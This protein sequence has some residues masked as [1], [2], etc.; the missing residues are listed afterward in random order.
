M[1][2]A[3]STLVRGAAI[4][5]AA[6]A[7]AIATPAAAVHDEFELDGDIADSSSNPSPDWA[8]FFDATGAQLPLPPHFMASDFVRDF[9][10]N[11][12][13]PDFTTFTTGSKD[14]L[15]IG[16]GWQCARSSN[17]NSK[18]DLLNTYATFFVDPVTGDRQVYFGLERASNAGD[19]NVAI[20]FLQD[21][22]VG[23]VAP[24]RGSGAAYFAGNHIDGDLLVVSSFTNGGA[25]STVDVFKWEGGPN[26]QLNPTPIVSG[27]DCKTT[28]V[29]DAV[30]ATVNA[31]PVTPPW[32][33]QDK[34]GNNV[35]DASEFFEGGL[36]VT[37]SAIHFE[38]FNRVLFDT[39]S[40]Q[41][42][43]ATLFDYTLGSFD[44][45]ND[46]NA[47]TTDVCDP[48]TGCAYTP[49]SCDDGNP[50]TDDSC[51]PAS[52][53]VHTANHVACNDGNACTTN[54]TCSGGQC[55][56]GVA[57]SCDDG[58]DCTDDTC[59]PSTGCAHTNNKAACSDGNACTLNDTC[60]A[61]RCV[62][63]PAPNCD[64][65]NVCTDDS[66][67]AT[68]GCVHANN[69]LPCSDGNSC[70]TSDVCSGGHCV[71][72]APPNCD[73]GNVCTDDTC[74]PS[75]GCV[76]TNNTAP[77]TDGN[78]CTTNDTCSHGSCAGG[79]ALNC[80]DSN[81]CTDDSCDPTT[82]CLHGNNTLPCNDGNACTTND[83]CSGG[84]CVGGAGP[85]CDDGNLC[86]DDT[87]SPSTG[88][89]H[90][91]NT[92]PCNDGNACT[93]N[94]ACSGGRCVGGAAPNCNDGNGCTDDGCDLATGCVHT[95]NTAPCNDGNACTT[96]DA[97]SG[98]NCVGG[99]P[100]SCDD[101]N[102]C[103]DD[104][105]NQATGCVHTNNAAPCSDGNMCTTNDA[106][107]GGRCVGGPA[108]SCDDGNVCTDDT[109]NPSTGCVHV[110]NTAPCND[111]NACTTND[112][113]SGGTCT[114]GGSATVPPCA[115]MYPFASSD[116][117]TSV[118]F[119]ES[120]VLRT[121]SPTG[122]VTATPGLTIKLWY[123]DEHALTL[124]VRQ[125][126]VKTKTGTAVTDY[127]LAALC[128]TPTA[129]CG[130][131]NPQ[132]GTTAL[133]GDQAGTDT[134]TCAGYPDLCDRPMFPALFITDITTDP[135]SKAGDWQSGGTPL[136]PNAVF[137]T[138]KAAVR[139]V[140]KTKSPTAVT[141][142]P[143]PDPAKNN[144]NLGGGDPVPDAT[145]RNE[146]YGAEVR[147]NVDA[148]I[149]A[150]QMVSGRAY[151]LQFMVHDGDQN[152]AGGDSGENC[153]DLN[154]CR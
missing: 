125:V 27:A 108:P 88:C 82:G 43:T 87:C 56:G 42:L 3:R 83:A 132:V 51:D 50:C 23:C 96:N 135:T 92:A 22:Q 139:T 94:D 28:A 77:C 126:S 145:L 64:D 45:C 143:D 24:S 59:S 38:C 91:N 61:G 13:G 75:T 131:T 78:A 71:G 121:F 118:V 148:L 147:W 151:R 122:A 68:T 100:P 60:S 105:C 150:G 98:G 14:T 114:G 86:T 103:T 6:L 2:Y 76:H 10:P 111:G 140:D 117:R 29:G 84:R 55:I 149:T 128:S 8:S 16:T 9:V 138:W 112:T 81:L 47:C 153:V 44:T 18:V 137:G 127:P 101:G 130:V 120:E 34:D 19:G 95:N 36:N 104:G 67:N 154:L 80:N 89:A 142:T 1:G 134:S 4:G 69:A 102:P 107:S 48:V 116:P 133:D 32:A 123:N 33:T 41:S 109:C 58:N 119:N 74:S 110:N 39:R 15:P 30:C 49:I 136:P 152:K 52:G 70:T 57:P 124:G 65:G 141:V 73:D 12:T 113:C 20:W 144:W 79:P 25:V 31:N 40:S 146:G 53:C 62:G 115:I 5:C 90:T 97:C 26:G 85:N 35:L 7:I 99:A 129:G 72:G 63:G 54:D 17:V 11:A 37:R 66:C 93:T 106:C 21:G 46:F